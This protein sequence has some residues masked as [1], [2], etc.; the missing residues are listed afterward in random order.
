MLC[1]RVIMMLIHTYFN[2]YKTFKKG[3]T[4]IRLRLLTS[5]RLDSLKKVNVEEVIWEKNLRKKLFSCEI[6]LRRCKTIAKKQFKKQLKKQF[7]KKQFKK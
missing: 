1:I 4:K 3:Y 2:I 5:Q 7:K 6:F